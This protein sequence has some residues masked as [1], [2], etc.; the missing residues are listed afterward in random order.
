MESW[1]HC[2]GSD[3]TLYYYI[4]NKKSCAAGPSLLPMPGMALGRRA[5]A[6]C[7]FLAVSQVTSLPKYCK[8][9]IHQ[10]SD[11]KFGWQ[12]LSSRTPKVNHQNIIWCC[13]PM[14]MG[15]F[16]WKLL[17]PFKLGLSYFHILGHKGVFQQKLKRCKLITVFPRYGR[18]GQKWPR[19]HD[20][21][22]Q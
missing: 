7:Y 2:G 20:L 13:D 11:M 1:Q 9:A 18:E 14:L 17:M 5:I 15:I 10:K 21:P 16:F 4:W 6:I 8:R 3:K 12:L 22:V 19:F